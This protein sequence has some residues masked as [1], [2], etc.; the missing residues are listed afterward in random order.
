MH[1]YSTIVPAYN[2]AETLEETLTA[3]RGQTAPCAEILVVDD[4]STDDTVK[5]ANAFDAPVRVI[6]QENAGPGAA[7][8]AGLRAATNDLIAMCDAD[9]IWVSE[10]MEKQLA[11]FGNANE[12][13]FT[14][15]A[16]RQFRH[17]SVDDGSGLI[18]PGPTR[19]TLV[20]TRRAAERTGDLIDPQGGRGDLIDWFARAREAGIEIRTTDDVLALRRI[21]P[22]S[23]SYGRDP[24]RDRGYLEVVR[25][26]MQRKRAKGFEN[27]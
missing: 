22:G 16:M 13:L 20:V 1:S 5:I 15:S 12:M 10:K 23:L 17:G 11:E 14:S 4:G 24:A 19:S 9:D 27:D 6:C 3:I 7:T 26:A 8:N 21:I 18:R 25:L 2:A